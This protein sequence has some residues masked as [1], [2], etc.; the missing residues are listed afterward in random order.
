MGRAVY[1]A[2]MQLLNPAFV[3]GAR[4]LIQSQGGNPLILNNDGSLNPD[5]VLSLFWNNLEVRTSVTPPLLFP[6]GPHGTPADPA[7]DA[8]IRS[9]KPTVILKGPAGD[10]VIAPYG[11]VVAQSWGP[12]VI[13]GV[14]GLGVLG[15][16][17]FGQRR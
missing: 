3:P 9:L 17:V 6:I 2:A 15:W 16:L 5:G 8:L 7:T 1:P 13:G 14:L 10:V 4:A 11:T 12:V